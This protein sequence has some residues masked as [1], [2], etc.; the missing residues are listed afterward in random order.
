MVWKDTII[1]KGENF[2]T[3]PAKLSVVIKL[4]NENFPLNII[5][6]S[7]HEIRSILPVFVS[8]NKPGINVKNSFGESGYTS[9]NIMPPIIDSISPESG[10]APLT[11][12]L[13]GRNLG[14]GYVTAN[15]YFN[16][17]LATAQVS[18]QGVQIVSLPS[19]L[20][21]GPVNVTA[22]FIGLTTV[23]QNFFTILP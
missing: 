16:Q 21:A 20:P 5:K 4:G 17:T 14:F 8:V 12:R 22:S 2:S 1:I 19:G 13:Y 9:F 7:I 3:D 23:K 10:K 6:S 11:V 18:S 15:V